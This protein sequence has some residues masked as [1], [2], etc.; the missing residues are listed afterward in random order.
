MAK[1]KTTQISVSQEEDV[2]AQHM[3]E[4][5]HQIATNLHESKDREQTEA[6][7]A[8]INTM[9]EGAQ[10]AL[11]KALSKE[12]HVDAADVVAALNELSPLKS[13]RKE[14]RRSLIQ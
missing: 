7:L 2:Q 12:Q 4:Q 8:E 10:I 1:K 3:L 13:V 11:L 5:Y 9:P 14:A 6:V